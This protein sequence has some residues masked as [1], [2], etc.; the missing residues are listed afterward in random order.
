MANVQLGPSKHGVIVYSADIKALVGFYTALFSMQVARETPE[1]VSL[2]KD[3]FNIIIHTP[4]F[5]MPKQHFSAVKLFIT[6]D[7]LAAAKLKAQQL[8]GKVFDGE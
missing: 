8:G 6:V 3:G 5:D 2:V 1:L 4:P 7:S